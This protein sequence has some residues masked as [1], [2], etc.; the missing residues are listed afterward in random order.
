MFSYDDYPKKG[1]Q[2]F[3]YDPT[4]SILENLNINL[5]K[6]MRV[7]ELGDDFVLKYH[8]VFTNAEVELVFHLR[9]S[10]YSHV[11]MER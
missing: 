5:H 4:I 9:E 3:L 7:E 10:R 1:E 2:E 6:G 11:R 8:S